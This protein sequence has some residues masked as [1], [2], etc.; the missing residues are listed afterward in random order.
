MST[1]ADALRRAAAHAAATGTPAP[2]IEATNAAPASRRGPRGNRQGPR[3]YIGPG[4]GSWQVLPTPPTFRGTS[5]QVCGVWP[6][7][8]GSSRPVVGVPVGQDIQTGS[9]VCCDPFSWFK[10]GLISAP[11]MSIFGLTG[12][13]KSSFAVRQILGCA[14]AGVVPLMAGDLK[15]EYSHV[16][17]ALGGQ[18]LRFG[19][20]QRLNLLDLGALAEAAN[21]VG[22]QRA[23]ELRDIAI[24]RSTIAVA[25]LVEIAR[26]SRLRDYEHS[27]L[28]GAIRLLHDKHRSTGRDSPT[29]ADLAALVENPTGELRRM[30]LA[31][32]HEEYRK[33]TKGL[34]RSLQAVVEGPLGRT[35]SGQSTERLHLDAPAVSIDIS[36]VEKRSETMLAAV[37]LAAWSEAFASIEAANALADAGQAPQRHFLAVMDEMWRPMRLEDA[38]LVDRLDGITRLNRAEGVGNIFV[39][40]SLKDME[41]MSSAADVQKA[42]GFAERSGIVVTAALAKADL[43]A[44]S[45]IKRLSE[46]EINTVASWSTPPGWVARTLRDPVTGSERPAPPPDAGKVLIKIGERAGIQTQVKLTPTELALHDTNARWVTSGDRG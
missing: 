4:G 3:G 19:E 1:T 44:L 25:A 14:A 24:D 12:F 6:F 27:L 10:A 7:A 35:F 45:E 8:G 36:V 16:V 18:V 5:V 39:T 40:H 30:V 34:R 33:E 29:I 17:R 22:G 26:R 37:M 32:T 43:R 21:R 46:T 13:G 23:A 38:G 2:P 20:H 42:R 11:S 9:T 28:A 41:S 15:G 31:E